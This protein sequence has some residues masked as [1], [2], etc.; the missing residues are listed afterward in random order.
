MSYNVDIPYGCYWSTPFARWQGAYA[1]LHSMEFAA[2]VAKAELAKRQIPASIFDAAVM[3]ISVPQKHSFFGTPWLTAMLGAG[4]VGG[5]TISQ[6]CATGVR[7]LQAASQEVNDGIAGV[8]L[9]MTC[10][11]TANGPHVF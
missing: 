6:A 8:S 3:G 9:V 4:Q 7:C 2:H 11:R 1:N 10:D 5:P